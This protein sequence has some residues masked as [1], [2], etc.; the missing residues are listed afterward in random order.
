MKKDLNRKSH[1]G[2]EDLV[3]EHVFGDMGQLILC[4]IF[5]AVWITSLTA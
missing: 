3:G 5:F 4:L 2:R 1:E